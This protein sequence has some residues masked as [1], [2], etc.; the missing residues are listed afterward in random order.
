VQPHNEFRIHPYVVQIGCYFG[1]G[2]HTD[3]YLVEGDPLTIIDTGVNDSPT[4]YIGPALENCGYSLKDVKL[5]LNTHGHYDHTGGNAEM[6]AASGA[7]LWVHEADAHCAENPDYQFETY[8]SN[9]HLL[10]GRRDRLETAR[11][12]YK[13][14]VGQATKV[15]RTLASDEV[16]D[17][18]KGIRLR[19]VHTP[20]H[21]PGSVCFAW[22]SEGLFMGGDSVAGLSP[23]P[24]G[25]PLI[26]FPDDYRCSIRRLQELDIA[27]LALA[28]H[29]QT[30]TV[31]TDSI[32]VKQNVK[33]FLAE[34]MTTLDLIEDAMHRAAAAR[35]DADFLEVA[36]DATDIL[37]QRLPI[38]KDI[39]GL[40]LYGNVESFYG[41][42]KL[43]KG[44]A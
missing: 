17:L 16:V 42:W 34:A 31:P 5:I 3:L 12:A 20:G 21:S 35:P 44:G 25:L 22:E 43:M 13:V 33:K 41:C 6:V 19:V 4:K 28:H 9:R 1:E 29:Y 38:S 30:L 24:G 15:N 11:D 7:Q 14:F 40:P 8:F 37:S 36:R 32:H 26:F 10:V 39:D 27:T 2:G 18:G 23:L